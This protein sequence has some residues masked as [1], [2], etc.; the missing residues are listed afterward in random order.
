MGR[1]NGSIR[2]NNNLR[3]S[4]EVLSDLDALA[5]RGQITDLSFGTNWNYLAGATDDG[6]LAIWWVATP[7]SIHLT[8]QFQTGSSPIYALDWNLDNTQ[9]LTVSEEVARCSPVPPSFLLPHSLL[10]PPVLRLPS[11]CKHAIQPTAP[12]G[13]D[14][15]WMFVCPSVSWPGTDSVQLTSP[16]GDDSHEMS[17]CPPVL[18]L[19][20]TAV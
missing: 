6:H 20:T 1:D 16:M 11:L 19:S 4:G 13:D 3:N 9:L 18:W 17:V 12:T 15:H 10:P 8:V 5:G 14:S 2:L 7:G